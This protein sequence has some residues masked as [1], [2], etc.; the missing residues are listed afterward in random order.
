[1]VVPSFFRL[2]FP[3]VQCAAFAAAAGFYFLYHASFPVIIAALSV[4]FF[5]FSFFMVLSSLDRQSRDLRQISICSTAL[6]IGLFFGM[7]AADAGRNEINFGIPEENVFAI[8]GV[9]LEDPRVIS[10][11]SV[12]ASLSLRA[13]HGESS[14]ASAAGITSSLHKLRVSAG[15]EIIVFFPKESAGNLKNFGRGAVVFTEGNLRST[16]RGKT[17]S[18][19]SLHVI[20]NAPEIEK[21]RT[22]IRTNL[23]NHFS[24]EEW[25]GL[26]LALLLGVRDNMDTD[27]AAL[28]RDA[29]LS[30]ILALSGMHLAIIAALIAFMFKRPLG[31]K[32]SAVTGT[33]L[34]ILYCFLVGPMPSLNRSALMYVLGVAAILGALPKNSM[35]I[36]SLSFILQLI[37]T[38][39]AGNSLS[40]ILSYLALLGILIIGRDFSSL[41]KGMI[42]DFI[43]QPLS[44]SVGAFLATAGVCSFVF[45]I[46]AP[47]GIIAGLAIVPLTT[48][49]MIGSMLYLVLDY[50][51]LSFILEWPLSFIYKLMEITASAAGNVPGISANPLLILA[52]SVL[53]FA[54]IVF[55]ERK[56]QMKIL[57]LR[58]FL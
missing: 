7:C 30:Y 37:L 53:L 39:A 43:L 55:I 4:S 56:R 2:S 48:V 28:Y 32:A 24:E 40:F 35:S 12:M 15:G 18:A 22:G 58:P 9:L 51:S 54:F 17:F 16:D 3:P 47:V 42:P 26:A 45:G 33:V 36:L 1:M 31:L 19:K 27:F 38:P 14:G 13:S 52:L 23:I 10:S 25:G 21:M 8:E 46:I 6:L 11:G 50:I 44:M 49:F 29:G 34:I 20:K 41:L 5:V 57:K